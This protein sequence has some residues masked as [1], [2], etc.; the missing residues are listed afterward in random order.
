[1]VGINKHTEIYKEEVAC[2]KLFFIPFS[3]ICSPPG[4][5]TLVG[6]D[7]RGRLGS[8]AGWP[9]GGINWWEAPTDQRAWEWRS[10]YFFP[11]LSQIQGA[12][13]GSNSSSA[14]W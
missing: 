3:H 8:L 11:A 2:S 9:L 5:Q 12:V 13:S 7:P 1:M 14:Q 4:R 6:E 10:R